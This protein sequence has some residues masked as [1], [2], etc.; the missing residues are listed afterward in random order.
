MPRV[1]ARR[2]VAVALGVLGVAG[3]P[4]TASAQTTVTLQQPKTHAW[5]ATL[6]GGTYADTNLSTILETRASSDP[7][8]LRR[9][10]LKFDTQNTVPS[11]ATISNALLTVTVKQGSADALRRIGIYQVTTSWEDIEVTYRVRKTATAW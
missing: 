3:V 7:E 9:S 1:F 10:L 8:Y 6:R 2:L 4:S 11:G 5:Y